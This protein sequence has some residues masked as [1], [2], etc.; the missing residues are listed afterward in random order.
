M[1]TKE[2]AEEAVRIWKESS[3]SIS[4]WDAIEMAIELYEEVDRN[5]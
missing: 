2:I 4:Y 1:R 3:Y 5:D